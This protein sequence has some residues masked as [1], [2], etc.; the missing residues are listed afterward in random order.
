VQ[1][2]FPEA[3]TDEQ[4]EAVLACCRRPRDQFLVVLLSCPAFS[5]QGIL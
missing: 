3:L 5:G 1:T 4:A 2:P